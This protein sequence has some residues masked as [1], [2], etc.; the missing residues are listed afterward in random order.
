MKINR[1]CLSSVVVAAALLA[2]VGCKSVN[3]VERAQPRATP[4]VV[5]TKYLKTD[6]G[7]KGDIALVSVVQKE[8]PDGT[9]KIQAEVQNVRRT[10]RSFN[11]KVQWIDQSGMTMDLP[12]TSWKPATLRGGEILTIPAVAP[13][14]KA[15]DF[16]LQ[17]VEAR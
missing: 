6:P 11:Y 13:S 3:T 16:R 9:L 2:G 17:L 15:V 12:S 1:V 8:L 5:D 7:L 14:P 4:D 10:T